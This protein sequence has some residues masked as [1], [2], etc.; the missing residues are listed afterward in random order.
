M[1]SQLLDGPKAVQQFNQMHRNQVASQ[2]EL[3][4]LADHLFEISDMEGMAMVLRII[5]I[6]NGV[7]QALHLMSG[8]HY[9]EA[10]QLVDDMESQRL[11]VAGQKSVRRR[12]K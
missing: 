8:G 5:G 10:Q 6:N 1:S 12:L 2:G 11:I 3:T 4:E 7:V 9:L